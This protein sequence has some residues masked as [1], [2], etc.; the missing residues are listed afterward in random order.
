M[1]KAYL[2]ISG[3]LSKTGSYGRE[4]L[5]IGRR[6]FEDESFAL[7]NPREEV[8]YFDQDLSWEKEVETFVECIRNDMPIDMSSSDDALKVMQLIE[9]AYKNDK[10][11]VLK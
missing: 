10:M 9:A 1:E 2:I 11:S 8:V 7:G 4:T 6:Q 5:T 3:L